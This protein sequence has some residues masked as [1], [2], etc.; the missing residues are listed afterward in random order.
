MTD[1]T[2]EALKA[3]LDEKWTNTVCPICEGTHW[4]ISTDEHV[5][6]IRDLVGGPSGLMVGIVICTDCGYTFM[7]STVAAGIRGDDDAEA[8]GGNS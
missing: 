7:V 8:D 4:S 3:H 1:K 2:A 6:I 5:V